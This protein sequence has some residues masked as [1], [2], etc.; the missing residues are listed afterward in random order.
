MSNEQYTEVKIALAQDFFEKESSKYVWHFPK[1]EII[2][3]DDPEIDL[4]KNEDFAK[5]EI[6]MKR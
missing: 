5:W 1:R 6:E 4:L 3:G 2:D